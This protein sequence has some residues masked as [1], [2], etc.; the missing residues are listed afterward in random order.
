MSLLQRICENKP[1]AFSLI[2]SEFS[3]EMDLHIFAIKPLDCIT[4]TISCH[5]SDE[6][7]ESECFGRFRKSNDRSRE[8]LPL[9]SKV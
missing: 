6:E 2:N 3:V 4:R 9:N 7:K 5:L 8:R 1:K